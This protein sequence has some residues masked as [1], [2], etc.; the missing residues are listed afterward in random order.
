[1]STKWIYSK[2]CLYYTQNTLTMFLSAITVMQVIFW[3][4]GSF[5]FTSDC[6][7]FFN[8]KLKKFINEQITNFYNP[9]N[10]FCSSDESVQM[11]H[12]KHHTFIGICF[13]FT[14]FSMQTLNLCWWR[15]I[16]SLGLF[17]WGETSHLDETSHLNEILFIP[18]FHEK[19]IPSEWDAF[20]PG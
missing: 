12:F 8:C 20:H 11:K 13:L 17:I 2:Y 16:E 10:T 4:E 6:R 7:Y 1:M 9:S 18:R 5:C 15:H 19:H 14:W 3:I